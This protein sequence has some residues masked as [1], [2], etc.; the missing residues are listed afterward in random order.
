MGAVV[1]GSAFVFL[2]GLTALSF[3]CHFSEEIVTVEQGVADDEGAGHPNGSHS[4]QP[5]SVGLGDEVGVVKHHSLS[6]SI[7]ISVSTHPS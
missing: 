5:P 3:D 1:L 7:F 6:L 4:A 2:D